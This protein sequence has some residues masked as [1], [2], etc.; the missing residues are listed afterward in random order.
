M[1]LI[2]NSD[3]ENRNE[4][5][6]NLQQNAV[7]DVVSDQKEDAKS[8]EDDAVTTASAEPS[9]KDGDEGDSEYIF[10]IFIDKVVHCK[11]A[12]SQQNGTRL[13]VL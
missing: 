3:E 7:S 2:G 13:F 4:T 9:A 1:V 6:L 8:M 11:L 10:S 12:K 5:A